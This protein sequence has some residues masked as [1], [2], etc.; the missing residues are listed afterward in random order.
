MGSP[1]KFTKIRRG[2][3]AAKKAANRAK[4]ANKLLLKLKKAGLNPVLTA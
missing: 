3:K 4:N 1:T 2:M